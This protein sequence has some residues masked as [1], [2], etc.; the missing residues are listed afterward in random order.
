MSSVAIE[1]IAFSL[2][3]ISLLWVAIRFYLNKKAT[4]INKSIEQLPSIRGKDSYEEAKEITE[5]QNQEQ[6]DN[7][8]SLLE[9]SYN[10][11]IITSTDE[12]TFSELYRPLFKKV[13]AFTKKLAIFH[14]EPSESI[15]QFVDDYCSL[16]ELVKNHNKQVI[17]NRLLLYK[18][19]FDH[20]LPYPLDI[21]QR[22]SILSEEDNCLVI[23]SA[24]SGKT[25]SIVGK[26]KYL[27][28]IKK[29]PIEQILLI[30]YTNKAAA[31]LTERVNVPKLRGY[32]FH[33][34]A[35]DIISQ[36]TGQKP[37]ICDNTDLL[38][39]NLYHQLLNKKEFK[40][41]IIE[42]FAEYQDFESDREKQ[43]NQQ[44]RELL[45]QKKERLKAILPDMD[46]NSVYV[47]SEQERT[48]CFVLSS[49][50][51]NYRYEEPYEHTVADEMHSQY[52][53]DFSIHYEK[54]GMHCRIYLEHFGVDE[55]GLVPSW[56]AKEKCISYDEANKQYGDG[57][58]WKKTVHGKFGT[59]M[60]TTSSA[61][62]HYR[63][64]HNYLKKQLRQYG[65]PINE[66]SDDELCEMILPENSQHEKA[67][68]RLIITFITLMKSSCVS[69]KDVLGK[70]Y[71]DEHSIFTIKNI[72]K[73]VYE[74]YSLEL[75]KRKE[76]DF[77]DAILQATE[78]I[79]TSHPS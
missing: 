3:V 63:N 39:I 25:S 16:S 35:L 51:L 74:A 52:K 64:I 34:L 76:I 30:S 48:I 13:Y 75:Q 72:I 40:K 26:V 66:K 59:K 31:E 15:S 61:D 69:I 20:C 46:G 73:P 14:L 78:L 77:T 23:S 49:L 4:T 60:I 65:V 56:F 62:F 42:Y 53:P 18:D 10:N 47:K 67:F 58:T 11:Q 54:N 22:R 2:F 44:R 71:H 1:I 57:I 36:A 27:I 6:I 43:L 8:K 17:N 37:A 21:Q 32:T 24:G 41:R 5:K 19:F 79:R 9:S 50:G 12:E 45:R 7:L 29:I 38:I 68:I 55:H 70:A 33:K 28:D